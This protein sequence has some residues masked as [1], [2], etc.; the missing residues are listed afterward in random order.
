LEIGP[1]HVPEPGPV[2]ILVR[3]LA[4]AINPVDWISIHPRR[5]ML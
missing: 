1:V 3:N 2:E 5:G 4:V